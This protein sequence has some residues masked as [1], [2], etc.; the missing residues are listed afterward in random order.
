MLCLRYTGRAKPSLYWTLSRFKTGTVQGI[1]GK[2]FNWTPKLSPDTN[3]TGLQ[4][5]TDGIVLTCS[6]KFTPKEDDWRFAGN[7]TTTHNRRATRIVYNKKG[8]NL[9]QCGDPQLHIE[10]AIFINT[11]AA[12]LSLPVSVLRVAESTQSILSTL[13]FTTFK[14]VATPFPALLPAFS[15]ARFFQFLPF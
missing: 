3:P 13:C 6:M 15:I 11:T 1:F 5:D 10:L 12:S 14:P 4:K 9:G 7:C 2:D 8:F